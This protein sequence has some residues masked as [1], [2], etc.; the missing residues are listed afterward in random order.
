MKN[1]LKSTLDTMDRKACLREITF[2]FGKDLEKANESSNQVATAN[3]LI[4]YDRLL[5]EFI[6]CEYE[7][8]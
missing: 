8:G 5:E 3:Y 1:G 4:I 7:Q 2:F 6:T